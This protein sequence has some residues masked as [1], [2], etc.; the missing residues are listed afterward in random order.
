MDQPD[1]PSLVKDN[2]ISYLFLN[3]DWLKYD[4]HQKNPTGLV[5]SVLFKSIDM[6][7]TLIGKKSAIN[8]DSI[9][10]C[11]ADYLNVKIKKERYKDTNYKN[12]L[13]SIIFE[14]LLEKSPDLSLYSFD[15]I[16]MSKRVGLKNIS[17]ELEKY[18]RK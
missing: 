15:N 10:A 5:P 1:R 16:E 14:K 11:K 18:Y 12:Y 3:K 4:I 6:S 13:V 7:I 17:Y 8:H 9:K 2:N